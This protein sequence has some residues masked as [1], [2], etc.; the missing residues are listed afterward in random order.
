MVASG[1]K[2][3]HPGPLRLLSQLSPAGQ[4]RPIARLGATE[5]NVLL[6]SEGLEGDSGGAVGG[7]AAGDEADND[8]DGECRYQ[9]RN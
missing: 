9:G 8:A 6:V 3:F 5:G 4:G 2:R 7:I 1:S